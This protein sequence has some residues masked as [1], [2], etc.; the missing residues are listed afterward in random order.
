MIY[1]IKAVYSFILPP[2]LFLLLLTAASWRMWRKD[3]KWAALPIGS[4]LLLYLLSSSWFSDMLMRGLEQRYD[5]SAVN[6]LRGDV[7]VVLGAGAVPDSPD[8]GGIG[9]M[10]GSAEARLLAA[11]RLS[12]TTGLPVLFSGGQVFPDS[13]NEA[14]IAGRQLRELGFA[15]DQIL[16]ENKSLN[17]EQNALLTRELME[18]EGLKQPILLTSAFHL[19]RAM[20]QF[21][22]AGLEPQPFPVDYSASLKPRWYWSKL[23]P[24]GSALSLSTTALKE[25]LGLAALKLS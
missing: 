8:L 5:Q 1:F 19:P 12:R 9:N 25:Y 14:N 15:A 21:K 23:L 11:A 20:E 22:R 16:L 7:I 4:L 18:K 17:T 2:G 10:S 3:R 13:G 6:E 24:T